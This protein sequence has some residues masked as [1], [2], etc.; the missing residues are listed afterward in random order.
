MADKKRQKWIREKGKYSKTYF[1]PNTIIY[2]LA[3]IERMQ[4]EIEYDQL[5]HQLS[6][7]HKN[8]SVSPGII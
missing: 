6:P 5:K 8:P 1:Q 7:R 4:L 2:L 3:E